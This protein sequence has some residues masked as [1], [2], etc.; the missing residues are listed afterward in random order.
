MNIHAIRSFIVE[1]HVTRVENYKEGS[2]MLLI[3][4]VDSELQCFDAISATWLSAAK[5]YKRGKY[6]QYY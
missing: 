3:Q 6:G 5:R 4:N 2:E 1:I